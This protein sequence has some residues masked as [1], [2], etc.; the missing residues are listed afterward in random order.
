MI[1][2]HTHSLF[3]DGELIPSELVRRCEALGYKAVAI[4]DHADSSTLD[5]I[6]PRIVQVAEALSK[7]QSVK[8]IPGIELTHVPPSLIASLTRQARELGAAIVVVHGETV[9]EPVSPGTNRAAIEARADILAHPGLLTLE[10][11]EMAAQNGVFLEI[12]GRSGHSFTN[13]HVANMGRQ[14]GAALI[15]NSDAHSP[16]DLLTRELAEKIAAGAGLGMN[17]LDSLLENSQRL[18][19]RCL[20]SR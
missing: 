15:L 18:L 1:D 17:S 20:S 10:E 2:L 4:T 8:V 9:V 11:A 7:N 5:F 14:A 16:S 12:S 13:G 19:D 3:S 6:I